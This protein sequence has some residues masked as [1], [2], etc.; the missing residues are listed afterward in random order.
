MMN[1]NI[2][3]VL[4]FEHYIVKKVV[5][6]Y[7]LDCEETE[8]GVKI[9]FD[10]DAHFEVDE[11][12]K[13]MFT[14]L[15]LVVF[16]NPVENNYPFKLELELVGVF[17]VRMGEE[18]D[19]NS[20]KANALAILFPYARAL[21]SSYTANSNITPLILPTININKFLADKENE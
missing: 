1:D 11:D 6:E 8:D 21:V 15:E 19:I 5:Y 16:D 14:F 3:S 7:N 2:K 17:S 10:I 13:E 18:D 12:K 20:Y 9:D 4:R